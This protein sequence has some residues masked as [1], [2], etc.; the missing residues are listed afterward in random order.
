MP[1]RCVC[2]ERRRHMASTAMVE[3]R[4]G[5][6]PADDSLEGCYPTLGTSAMSFLR[7]GRDSSSGASNSA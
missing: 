3:R 6:E 1:R 5:I 4:A 2:R 7:A